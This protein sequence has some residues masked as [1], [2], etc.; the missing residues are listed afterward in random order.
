MCACGLGL[1]GGGGGG[2]GGL[3]AGRFFAP[4]GACC[5]VAAAPR[6]DPD[7][8]VAALRKLPP[9]M[10]GSSVSTAMPDAKRR[11]A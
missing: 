4:L 6:P 7:T 10:F 5:D 2:E 3:T 9:P 11:S 1:A 8:G